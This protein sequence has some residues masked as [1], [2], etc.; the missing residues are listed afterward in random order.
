MNNLSEEEKKIRRKLQ[1]KAN[2]DCIIFKFLFA[3]CY[4][5]T[6]YKNKINLAK[7]YI[8]LKF[9]MSKYFI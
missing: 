4:F 7:K 6:I 8:S 9:F 2:C 3:F 1:T 5:S